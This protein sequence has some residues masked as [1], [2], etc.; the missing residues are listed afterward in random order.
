MRPII[1]LLFVI[2]IHSAC[3]NY[4]TL[5]FFNSSIFQLGLPPPNAFTYI[6]LPPALTPCDLE[7]LHNICVERVNS[8]RSGQLKFTGGGS[9]PGT[10]ANLSYYTANYR[11]SNA[12]AFGD[13]YVNNNSADLCFGA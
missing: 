10:R 13:F 1:I 9:D 4:S 11:C 3:V 12:I 5:G 2:P 8:Y 6:E 7:Y